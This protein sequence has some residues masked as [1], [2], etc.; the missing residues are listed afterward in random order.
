MAA[1]AQR[2]AG[3][4]AREPVSVAE[5]EAIERTR[6]GFIDQSDYVVDKSGLHDLYARVYAGKGRLVLDGVREYQRD[7]RLS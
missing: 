6:T 3:P 7:Y 4:D 5:Y 1:A 2:Q